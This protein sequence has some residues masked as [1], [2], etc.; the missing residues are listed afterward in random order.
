MNERKRKRIGRRLTAALGS[1][2]ISRSDM[3]R[4]CCVHN[5]TACRWADGIGIPNQK[6]RVAISNLLGI[7]HDILWEEAGEL[8]PSD[9]RMAMIDHVTNRTKPEDLQ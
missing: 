4:A 8:P 3:A 1:A 7:D 5:M 9:E 6:R 2:G